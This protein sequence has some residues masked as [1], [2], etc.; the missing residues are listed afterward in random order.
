MAM[1]KPDW[2]DKVTARCNAR[3]NDDPW[4]PMFSRALRAAYR[5]G[6]RDEREACA[7]VCESDCNI[8]ACNHCKYNAEIIRDRNGRVKR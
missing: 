3:A 6:Q 2:A 4:H 8:R 1:T 7:V 5:R